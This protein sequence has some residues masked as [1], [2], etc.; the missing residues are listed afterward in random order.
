MAAASRPPESVVKFRGHAEAIVLGLAHGLAIGVSWYAPFAW[1]W[2]L[3]LFLV[4]M[5]IIRNVH[6]AVR[7]ASIRRQLLADQRQE[8]EA[9]RLAAMPGE[10]SYEA[11]LENYPG[12]KAMHDDTAEF[13]AQMAAYLKAHREESGNRTMKEIKIP[14]AKTAFVDRSQAP[15]E[16]LVVVTDLPERSSAGPEA[17]NRHDMMSAVAAAVAEHR[18]Q[19]Y[20]IRWSE[21]TGHADN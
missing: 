11:L 10:Q 21:A 9:E 18:L 3:V 7:A 6:L 2:R 4:L 12:L 1:Y 8:M 19:G 13:R 20:E 16:T 15:R 14:H 5:F 17:D